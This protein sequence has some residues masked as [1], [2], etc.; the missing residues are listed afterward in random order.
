MTIY[1]K[2]YNKIF[3]YECPNNG[4]QYEPFPYIFKLIKKLCDVL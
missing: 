4:K 3:S 2:K 1:F